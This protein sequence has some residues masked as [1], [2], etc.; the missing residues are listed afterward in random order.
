MTEQLPISILV[1]SDLIKQLVNV[2]SAKVNSITNK[3]EA[4]FNFQTMT[5]NWYANEDNIMFIQLLLK[6]PQ[7]FIEQK[8]KQIEMQKNKH[9]KTFDVY[10][11]DV[12]IFIDKNEPQQLMCII[13]IT[14]VEQ[15]LV[16]QKEKI[17]NSLL[18]IK[19]QKILNIL[20][21]KLILQPI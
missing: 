4:Q 19:L 9:L 14:D 20:A 10:S 13:A 18:T 17:L 21:K 2:N 1:C 8:I 7:G 3:L 15:K 6:T 5:A 16:A 11:D 12:F